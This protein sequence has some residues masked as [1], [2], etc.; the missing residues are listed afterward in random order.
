M[1]IDYPFSS[2]VKEKINPENVVAFR[3]QPTASKSSFIAFGIFIQNLTSILDRKNISLDEYTSLQL[4]H[5]QKKFSDPKMG[6][7]L[8]FEKHSLSGYPGY[9]VE[10]AI[11]DSAVLPSVE[12]QIWTVKDGKAYNIM[13][14]YNPLTIQ[15]KATPIIAKMIDSFKI[16]K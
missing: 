8:V 13:Y 15:N 1:R 11:F 3:Y 12:T 16:T 14:T 2:T 6:E 10:Y 4:M 9:K 5:L 7:I